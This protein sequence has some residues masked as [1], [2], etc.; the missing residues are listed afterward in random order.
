MGMRRMCLWA[1][2]IGVLV[3]VGLLNVER[4]YTE[5]REH[6]MTCTL[7]TL[8]GRYL[9][10]V[11]GTYFPPAAGVTTQ[12]LFDRAGYRIF[13]GDGTGTSIA[14]ES[15]NGVITHADVHSN[16]TYTLNADCTGT[17]KVLSAGA[18]Q[19]IFVAPNGDDMT[20]IATDKGHAEAF[21]SW[22]VGRQ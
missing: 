20:V 18:T 17:L 16:L 10:V 4:G 1:P 6:T 22:R 15:I 8:K 3:S 12:S 21:S 2:T 13:D 14:T 7:D 19:E 11:N 5:E 9:F